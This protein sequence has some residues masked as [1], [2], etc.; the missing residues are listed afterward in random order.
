[1]VW[2]RMMGPNISSSSSLSAS[3]SSSSSPSPSC[4]SSFPFK[5]F[6]LIFNTSHN[7]WFSRTFFK[8]KMCNQSLW[9]WKKH[10]Q[11][12]PVTPVTRCADH[13]ETHPKSQQAAANLQHSRCHLVREPSDLDSR[14]GSEE[15]TSCCVQK[16]PRFL[17][18]FSKKIDVLWNH[19]G[20]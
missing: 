5:S 13:P 15:T 19:Y 7:P 8:T 20:Q 2:F 4:S 9:G 11:P 14:R 17:T 12:L 1:M 6:P 16:S 18:F 10:I 3:S